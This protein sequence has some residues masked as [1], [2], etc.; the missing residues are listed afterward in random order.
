MSARDWCKR[1]NV[2]LTPW[3]EWACDFLEMRGQRFMVDFGY[4]NAES[5]ADE[6]LAL[7]WVRH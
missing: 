2:H 4:E 1:Y 3:Q 7:D 6:S 5:K